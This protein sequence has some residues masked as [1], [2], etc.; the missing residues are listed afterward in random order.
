MERL[1]VLKLVRSDAAGVQCTQSWARLGRFLDGLL[2]LLLGAN[3]Q[4]VAALATTSCR[5]S[6]ASLP[7]Q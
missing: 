3:E 5:K 2:G 4:D 1:M 7:V 6:Q